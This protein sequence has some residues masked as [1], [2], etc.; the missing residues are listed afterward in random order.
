MKKILLFVIVIVTSLSVSA[1]ISFE[2]GYFINN[3]NQKTEC[4]IKNID[5]QNNPSEFNYKLSENSPI[6]KG[7]L[8][9]VKEFGIF[10]AN[11]YVR[12]T[13]NI[14]Q[15]S[16]LIEKLSES[17]LPEFKEEQVFLR[18]LIEGAATLYE[19]EN[20]NIKRFFYTKSDKVIEPLIFKLYRTPEN[21]IAQNNTFRQ[22]LWNELKCDDFTSK[23]L[24]HLKYEKKALINFFITY[25]KCNHAD[26]VNLE[27]KIKRDFFHLTLK[28]R[29]NFSSLTSSSFIEYDN[30]NFK[31]KSNISLGIEAEFILPFNKNKW[32][33]I[34]EPAYQYY[35]NRTSFAYKY[36]V[37]YILNVAIDYKSVELPMGL[38]HYFFLNNQSK[39]YVNAHYIINISSNDSKFDFTRSDESVFN[40]LKISPRTSFA[41]GAG[42][43][44]KNYGFEL[45]YYTNRNLLGDYLYYNTDYKTFSAMLSYS[46]F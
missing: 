46:I 1:Q 9:S 5:W 14:E 24:E 2:K 16:T 39:F 11:K 44:Y 35:K 3:E 33:I 42:Y 20:A 10:N 26:Y 38:R 31:E 41:F 18:V 13:T 28:P 12:Y 43:K 15:S 7:T 30:I 22:Q 40:S 6:E 21:Q 25:N 34:V 36:A 37:G 17:R 19:Y 23:D 45:R 27:E 8:L 32:S 29:V 4:L